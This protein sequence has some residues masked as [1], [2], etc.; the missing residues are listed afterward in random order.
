MIKGVCQSLVATRGYFNAWILLIDK[1]QRYKITAESGLGEAFRPLDEMLKRNGPSKCGRQALKQ[2][3]SVVTRDPA[4]VCLDCPLSVGYEGRGGITSRLYYR[5]KLYGLLC[6]SIP[7]S[8]VEKKEE[9]ALFEEIAR[10]VAFAL[11]KID[12]EEEHERAQE[13]LRFYAKQA[14]MAQEE[15]RKRIAWELHDETAQALASLGMDIGSLAKNKTLSST[16][17]AGKLK[18]LQTKTETILEG[19]R[20]LSKNLRPPMLQEFGLLTALKGLV[21]EMAEQQTIKVSFKVEGTAYRLRPEAEITTYRVVQEALT[22]IKKHAE[23]SECSVEMKY[24]PRRVVLE[25]SDK[26]RGFSIPEPSN[27]LAYS[28]RLGLAGMQERAKLLGGR[29]IIKSHPGQG[30]IVHLELPARVLVSQT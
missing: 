24:F 13:N 6:A 28:G 12:L 15:E 21:S 27:N 1:D 5:G 19:I 10:D 30:T 3:N 17:I 26:G 20:S 11:H 16:E 2:S 23:A 9:C 22:N 4:L 18:T 7:S 14:I 25:I 29:L 8:L